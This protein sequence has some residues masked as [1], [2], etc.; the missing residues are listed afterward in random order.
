MSV[1]IKDRVGWVVLQ[2]ALSCVLTHTGYMGPW[3]L[4]SFDGHQ[5]GRYLTSLNG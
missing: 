1:S 4:S 2:Q 5:V 3:K